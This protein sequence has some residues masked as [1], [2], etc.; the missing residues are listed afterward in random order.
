MWCT[1]LASALEAKF[2][3]R[4][5]DA[6]RRRITLTEPHP[7]GEPIEGVLFDFVNTLFRFDDA[8]WH[9]GV[10]AKTGRAFDARAQ[11]LAARITHL[12]V[13]REGLDQDY[14]MDRSP[15]AHRSFYETIYFEATD[16]R[17]LATAYYVEM[18]RSFVPYSDAAS[19]VDA[20]RAASIRVGLLSNIGF[21]LRPTL[22]RNGFTLDAIVLSF[23]EGRSKPDPRLFALAAARLGCRAGRTLM[24]GD[25]PV[26]DNGGVSI[27]IRT[28]ILPEA[29]V[30]HD[31]R[32]YQAVVDMVEM[33]VRG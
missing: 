33:S 12:V 32:C 25:D 9:A 5:R 6:G 28:M 8:A 26:S 21:D 15:L 3:D 10:Y 23:E 18:Q 4:V 11:E 14:M 2:V 20:L 30:Q 31:K 29:T 13:D 16:D 17:E 7:V 22:E 1:Q 27:G 19:T 24:V